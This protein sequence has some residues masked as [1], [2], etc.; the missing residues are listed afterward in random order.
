MPVIMRPGAPALA[1]MSRD[2]SPAGFAWV[3]ATVLVATCLAILG[4]VASPVF[5]VAAALPV[6]ALLGSAVAGAFV[7]RRYCV[8][9]EHL[10][11]D[12]AD[13]VIDIYRRFKL[14]ERMISDVPTGI[15]WAEVS[16]DVDTLMVEAA[17]HA[18]QMS[19]VDKQRADLKWADEG[20][21]AAALD[22]RLHERR[23]QH[24]DIL[25]AV[26]R[27]A[28]TLAR[29]AGNA[30]AAARV[31]L[32]ATGGDKKLLEDAVPSVEA[33]AAAGRLTGARA[34]LVALTEAWSALDTT[35]TLAIEALDHELRALD[36]GGEQKPT[37]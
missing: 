23:Q 5:F 10:S 29:L 26:Q 22:S 25:K 33:I 12:A 34:R 35:G 21:P 4:A 19:D 15:R 27:E 3:V 17:T 32:L 8:P 24:L 16:A 36:Q 13:L 1:R 20:T 6:A 7:A 31:A 14:A 28:D 2:P 9:T 18:L 11:A 30:A 37:T